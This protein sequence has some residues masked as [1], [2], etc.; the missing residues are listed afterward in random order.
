MHS[1]WHGPWHAL[2]FYLADQALNVL[3]VDAEGVHAW[4]RPVNSLQTRLLQVCTE[5]SDDQRAQVYRPA[6]QPMLRSLYDLLIPEE[7]VQRVT[8]DSLLLIAPHRHLHNLPFGALR[9]EDGRSLVELVTLAFTPSLHIYCALAE[10]SA[11]Q[12][13][14]AS[15]GIAARPGIVF[16]VTELG[17]ALYRWPQSE[18][19]P[20]VQRLLGAR[21]R[22]VLDDAAQKDMNWLEM[23]EAP[24]Q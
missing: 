15:P 23:N 18:P 7:V 5:H 20:R 24:A 8:P 9:N 13:M 6:T 16:G 12:R 10:R 11:A 17:G 22:L 21:G 4:Q 2:A 19:R 1:T 14:A 3:H